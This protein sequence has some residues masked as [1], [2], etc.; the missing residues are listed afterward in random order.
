M[1]WTE[2]IAACLG[3]V[4]VGLVVR[5]SVWNYP[6]GIAMVT[7]YGFV[8]FHARLYSDTILQGYY[9]VVQIYGWW[10]WL[11]GR[12]GDGLIRVEL[13]A[14]RGR[15]AAIAVTLAGAAAGGWFFANYT[16]A[17]APWLDAFIAS[18]SVT[19]QYLMSIRKIENWIWWIVVDVV[20]IGVYCWKGLYPTTAL[21][22]IFL[23]LSIWGLV[24][25][26]RELRAEQE[27]LVP[28]ETPA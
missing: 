20:A 5:R 28:E 10:Y 27:T 24:G 2:I 3:V 23:G 15:F 11:K 9:F 16:N 26:L 1:S 8:F 7:L 21:Y 13:M 6:F 19:A 14:T 17:A 4:N 22:A 25:W 18:A 12:G